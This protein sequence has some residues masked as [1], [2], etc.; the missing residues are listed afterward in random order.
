MLVTFVFRAAAAPLFYSRNEKALT[1]S[2]WA[3]S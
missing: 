3:L 1:E 2:G